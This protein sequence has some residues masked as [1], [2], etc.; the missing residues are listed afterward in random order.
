MNKF[1]TFFLAESFDNFDYQKAFF[2]TLNEY[3]RNIVKGLHNN[4]SWEKAK[5]NAFSIFDIENDNRDFL[6]LV[7][8]FQNDQQVELQFYH[9][10]KTVKSIVR[11]AKEDN[12]PTVI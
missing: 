9:N 1:K 8:L 2:M 3:A 12:Y 10:G 11:W 5:K 6:N 4:E 7:Q